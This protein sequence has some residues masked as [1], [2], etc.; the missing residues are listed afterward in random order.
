MIRLNGYGRSCDHAFPVGDCPGTQAAV[1]H[2]IGLGQ[3]QSWRVG[4]FI[5]KAAAAWEPS[6]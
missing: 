6:A 5:F 4:V 2:V 3:S 1:S